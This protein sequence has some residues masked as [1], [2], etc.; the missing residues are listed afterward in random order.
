MILPDRTYVNGRRVFAVKYCAICGATL[1]RK[2]Y[3]SRI[4]DPNVF[5]KRKYC[6]MKCAAVG[7][8]HDTVTVSGS[9]QRATRMRKSACELCGTTRRPGE[10]RLH[11]HHK[12]R[13][14]LNN[15][16]DN[17]MTVCA[18][19]HHDIHG[20]TRKKTCN[21]KCSVC[22]G[23]ARKLNMCN[24]HYERYRRHG[25]PLLMLKRISGQWV[26]TRLGPNEL[27][28]RHGNRTTIT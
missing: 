28:R 9:R 14:P 18:Q 2:R 6:D 21:F 23:P 5:E 12:D 19:C 11:V 15:A 25:D 4:E 8:L 24:V 3:G 27:G 10:R 17:L 20:N 1:Q 26:L 16:P 7:F 13:N 22:G